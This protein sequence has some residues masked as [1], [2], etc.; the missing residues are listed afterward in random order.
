MS[1]A[2]LIL[3]KNNIKPSLIRIK[4]LEYIMKSKTHPTAEEIYTTLKKQ[5]P[6]LSKTSIY[7]NLN[8]LLSKKIIKDIKTKKEQ[9]FD[10]IEKEHLNF[11]CQVCEKIFDIPLQELKILFKAR[12]FKVEKINLYAEGICEKCQKQFSFKKT[13]NTNGKNN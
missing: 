12:N 7:N 6:T 9:R 3:Q 8:I 13:I 4:I 1:K 5:I 10:Y 11:Y 2:Q